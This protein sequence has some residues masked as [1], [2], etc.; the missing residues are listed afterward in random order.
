[1]KAT[2]KDVASLAGVSVKTVSRVINNEPNVRP[3]M[4]DKV[5][6]AVHHLTEIFPIYKDLKA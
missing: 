3:A 4:Q 6:K 2:I 1:M 5:K